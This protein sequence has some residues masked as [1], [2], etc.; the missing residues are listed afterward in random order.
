MS[1]AVESARRAKQLPSFP[2]EGP[3]HPPSDN[4]LAA[5][6]RR[7]GPLGLLAIVII[8]LG[9]VLFVPLSAILV[10][11]WAKVSR[12]PWRELGFVRPKNWI[13]TVL[14]AIAFGITFKFFMKALVMPLF[15][16]P[17]MNQAYHFLAGNRAALPG[18]LYLIIAGAGFGEETFF[19]GWMFERFGKLFGASLGAKTLIV[20]ITSVWFALAHYA[21]QGLP[22]VQQA[23]I[24]GLTFGT[25]FAITGR[26]FM[27]MIAHAAF[28]LTALAMIY[29]KLESAVAHLVFQ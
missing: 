26:L 18:M 29:W 20:L 17:P 24:T 21:F 15:G 1:E 23:L 28:D 5:S 14:I 13:G 9:N 19:R 3:A 10:L 25:I 22:G 6:L 16:A 4:R 27:L 7:F 8:L 11:V 12:T 2:V